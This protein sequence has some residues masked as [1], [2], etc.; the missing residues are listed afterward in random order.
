MSKK[1]A[2]K[3]EPHLCADRINAWLAEKNGVLLGGLSLL[4]D[5]KVEASRRIYLAVD[6]LDPKKRI[7]PPRV[8]CSY[9][10]FCGK[11]IA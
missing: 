2:K 3:G 4:P 11:E 5:G 10:P 6:K 1:R 7:R 8:A 9:C